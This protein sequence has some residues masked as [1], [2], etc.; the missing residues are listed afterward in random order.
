MDLFKDLAILILITVV[1][2]L[3]VERF[4]EHGIK[5]ES[6]FLK[7]IL[8]TFALLLIAVLVFVALPYYSGM[9]F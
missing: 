2:Y 9:F 7:A 8:K 1:V 3:A 5:S 6:F 4:I